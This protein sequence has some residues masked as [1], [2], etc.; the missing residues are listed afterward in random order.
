MKKV[1]C[2]NSPLAAAFG[3]APP[4]SFATCVAAALLGC[5]VGSAVR[6]LC[7]SLIREAPLCG[8]AAIAFGGPSF[9][10]AL[11]RR[12]WA[13]RVAGHRGGWSFAGSL[14]C[15]LPLITLPPLVEVA[16]L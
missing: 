15:P 3:P 7:R 10:G 4:F 16:A 8:G 6:S 1:N 14:Q 13:M 11:A 5:S 9:G 12:Q 2:L